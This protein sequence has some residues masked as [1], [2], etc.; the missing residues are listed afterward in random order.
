MIMRYLK[1]LLRIALKTTSQMAYVF[2]GYNE[3][4]CKD[5]RN[6]FDYKDFFYNYG[7]EHCPFCGSD[8]WE[9]RN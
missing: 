3:C 7:R 1:Y 4:I 6:R 9:I 5:C 8:N 2:G